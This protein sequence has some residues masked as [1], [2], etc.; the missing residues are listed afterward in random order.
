MSDQGS[1]NAL[2]SQDCLSAIIEQDAFL[3]KR[4]FQY[5][6]FSPQV[7]DIILLMAINPTRDDE[8]E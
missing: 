3:A 1:R 2:L 4:L 8:E 5:F 6:V 7:L